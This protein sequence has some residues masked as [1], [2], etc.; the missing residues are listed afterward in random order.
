MAPRKRKY[1]ENNINHT[2]SKG[3]T[4]MQ[5]EQFDDQ[6]DEINEDIN[7]VINEEEIT[8]DDMNNIVIENNIEELNKEIEAVEVINETSETTFINTVIEEKIEA[9]NMPIAENTTV[10]LCANAQ[11]IDFS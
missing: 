3:N 1:K 10:F 7:E 9:T 4:I 8:G 11:R 5:S 6:I 2:N